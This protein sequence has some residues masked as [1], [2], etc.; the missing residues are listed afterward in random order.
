MFFRLGVV[1]ALVVDALAVHTYKAEPNTGGHKMQVQ[2]REREYSVVQVDEWVT[3]ISDGL[4][5]SRYRYGM[6]GELL[7]ELDVNHGA[8]EQ[9]IRNRNDFLHVTDEE[10][11]AR[12]EDGTY[13]ITDLD[14]WYS[15]I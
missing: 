6:D 3:C 4:C 8:T 11:S 13:T 2:E 5:V 14:F 15:S 10:V 9:D 7:V 1:D 12:I